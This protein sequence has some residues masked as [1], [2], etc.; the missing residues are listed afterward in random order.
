MTYVA[1]KRLYL[2]ADRTRAVEE[3]PEASFL[4]VADGGSLPDEEAEKYGLTGKKK[5]QAEPEPVPSTA[6]DP[7]PA[8]KKA[9]DEPPDTKAVSAPPENKA[10]QTPRS[11]KDR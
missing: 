7:E 8:E 4:L 9:Q 3:G 2:N 10:Q 1:D 5:A 11:T 6:A